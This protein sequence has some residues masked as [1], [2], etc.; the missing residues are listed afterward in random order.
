MHIALCGP[1]TLQLLE[2][3]LGEHIS[4]AG[5]PF[6]LLPLLSR[7]FIAKGHRVSLITSASDVVEERRYS[8]E[9]LT[10]VVVPSRVRARER[11]LDFFRIERQGVTRALVREAPDVINAH[12]TYE[13]ALGALSAQVAPTV[14]TAHDAPM[15]ILR[16]NRDAYRLIRAMMALGVRAR[17]ENVTAVSP[18]LAE[19]WSRELLYRRSVAVITNPCPPLSMPRTVRRSPYP[20]ILEVADASRRKNVVGLVEAF[21]SVR[22]RFPEASLRLVGPG[23]EHDGDTARWATSRDLATSVE[24]LGRLSR[25]ELGTQFA[26]AS[27]FCHV[28]LEESQGIC[29][30]EAM[31]AGIPIV[32]G[33]RSGAVPW[34]LADGE[35]GLLVDVTSPKEIAAGIV[36]VL[37]NSDMAAAMVDRGRR[38]VAERFSTSVIADQYLEV[39]HRAFRARGI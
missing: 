27:I 29:L 17:A 38:E 28:S 18:Y 23:L 2:P 15:T 10:L 37:G 34:T 20:I 32:A 25:E 4:S 36:E 35:A 19:R 24:F 3:L 16:A 31:S 6:P 22:A 26:E 12:W 8:A 13:F 11:A 9:R 7:E 39:Y 33:N 21:R 1:A 30:L 14:V 5:Y